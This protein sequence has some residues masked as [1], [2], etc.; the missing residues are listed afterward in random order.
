MQI[1][2]HPYLE[3]FF[4]NQRTKLNL[5]E[6]A[7]PIGIE[8]FKTNVLM[9]AAIHLGPNYI[10]DFTRTQSSRNFRIYSLLRKIDIGKSSRNFECD[11]D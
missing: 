7:P 9:K 8:A 1:S 10:V 6:I 11:N 4:K 2:D 3:T 5:A